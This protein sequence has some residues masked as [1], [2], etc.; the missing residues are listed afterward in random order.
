MHGWR[1]TTCD[2]FETA[3][4]VGD[5][6]L[7]EERLVDVLIQAYNFDT[8]DLQIAFHSP[9]SINPELV[10]FLPQAISKLGHYYWVT[11]DL[12]NAARSSQYTI[13]GRVTIKGL[14]EAVLDTRSIMNGLLGFDAALERITG[15]SHQRRGYGSKVLS[16]ARTKYHGRISRSRSPWKVH[17]EI[18]LLFFYEHNSNIKSACYLCERMIAS[19]T[20]GSCL[21]GTSTN[22]SLVRVST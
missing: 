4:D 5:P 15:L 11:C 8:K 16:L 7:S 6:S 14:E 19:T 17:A 18:Q 1:K 22:L 13:F 12:I 9:P 10:T 3:H 20:G 2:K 21:T